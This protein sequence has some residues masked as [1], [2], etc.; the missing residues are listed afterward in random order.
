MSRLFLLL[1]DSSIMESN[2]EGSGSF[3]HKLEG[4]IKHSQR[5]GEARK[6]IC[7][8]GPSD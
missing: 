5:I 8:I 6:M 1:I 3:V 4:K 7:E 2:C